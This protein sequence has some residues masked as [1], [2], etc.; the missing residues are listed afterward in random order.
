MYIHTYIRTN[1]RTYVLM[2]KSQYE[3][4]DD[5]ISYLTQPHRKQRYNY[6]P[7]QLG[8]ESS[9]EEKKVIETNVIDV[10]FYTASGNVVL[11]KQN[12]T[13]QP[14]SKSGNNQKRVMGLSY[15]AAGNMDSKKKKQQE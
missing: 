11:E 7:D 9:S 8:I 13:N 2:N 10:L 3:T 15:T 14:G 6:L 12:N 1:I 4:V 5:V